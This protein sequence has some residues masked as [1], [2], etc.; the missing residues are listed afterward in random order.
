MLSSSFRHLFLTDSEINQGEGG[1]W[2]CA[3]VFEVPLLGDG[4]IANYDEYAQGGSPCPPGSNHREPTGITFVDGYFYITDDD[5]GIIMRH[6]GNFGESLN[7]VTTEYKDAEGITFDPNAR[8][9]YVVI[10]NKG[11]VLVYNDDLNYLSK[12]AVPAGITD[13]EGIAY[14]PT[15]NHLFLVSTPDLKVYELELDGTLLFE[16]DISTF[17]PPPEKPQGLTVAPSSNPNDGANVLHLYISDGVS[18]VYEVAIPGGVTGN[19]PDIAVDP[20][21]HDFGDVDVG[22]NAQHIFVVSN[23]GQEDLH[24]SATS[25]G[26][27]NADN[28]SIISGEAPFTVAPG[29][30]HEIIVEFSPSFP[31]Q[32][33]ATLT[34]VSDDPDES[35]FAVELSGR[36]LGELLGDVNDDGLANSNDVLILISCDIDEDVSQHCPLVCGDVNDD[37]LVNTFDAL[38]ILAYDAGL[39]VPFPVAE[40]ECPASVTPCPGCE[41]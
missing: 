32:K 13:P 30:D 29:N 4:L 10:G 3:N 25:L 17:N 12:F 36:G 26:G 18:R 27:A 38:V 16:Y 39:S 20:T 21:S 35:P 19:L 22:A 33:T 14:S 34:I 28:F 40:A 7:Q 31:G 15:S 2:E 37:G 5:E 11:W 1:D 41:P 6:D 24:V 23:E 9:F 8:R